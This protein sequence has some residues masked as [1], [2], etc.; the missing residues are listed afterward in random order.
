MLITAFA[1]TVTAISFVITF[2]L[3]LTL[4]VSAVGVSSVT[5]L[6]GAIISES[7]QM[8]ALISVL[9]PIPVM[10]LMMAASRLSAS[11]TLSP[12]KR[13]VS[14]AMLAVLREITGAALSGNTNMAGNQY[15]LDISN[16]PII[17]PV[18][19]LM[20]STRQTFLLAGTGTKL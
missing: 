7:R 9:S 12:K 8:R 13:R 14:P 5:V 20:L 4:R 19:A 10:L 16:S 11:V 18:S 6:S 2:P 3:E 1:L 17:S 15:C